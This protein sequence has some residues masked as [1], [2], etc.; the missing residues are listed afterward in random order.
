MASLRERSCRPG[1]GPVSPM[2]AGLE[3][4]GRVVTA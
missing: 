4:A 2:N 1:D 3:V